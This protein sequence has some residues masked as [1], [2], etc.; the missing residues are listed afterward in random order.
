M[1][2]RICLQSWVP[3]R[4]LSSSKS[5]MVSSM[6]FGEVC[7]VVGRD[8]EW[9]KVSANIDGYVGWIPEI[10]LRD[11]SS[12]ENT[13]WDIVLEVGSSFLGDFG[14]R[15]LL[16]PGCLVP[17]SG[18]IVIDG[19]VYH[20]RGGKFLVAGA[21]A[22]A[23]AFLNTPYLWG[24][25]SIWGIDCSGLVQV[26][27]QMLH[28]N[29]PR[30]AYQQALCGNLEMWD[31]RKSGDLA[32]FAN[33]D[34]KVTHVG[35]LLDDDQIIHAFGKVRIDRLTVNGIVNEQSG[36]LTHKLHDIRTWPILL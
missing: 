1:V 29:M 20:Y 27:G 28:I 6:L 34:G 3:M 22:A 25:R 16:S 19:S 11:F 15:I 5:E 17:R 30:D 33:A 10:Y 31:Q 35:I 18:E 4:A 2:Q 26:V 32:Y 36:L 13:D 12:F 14:D 24:G 7:S 9:L 8:G 21:A 23:E